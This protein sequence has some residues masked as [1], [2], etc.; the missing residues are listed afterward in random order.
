MADFTPK[1]WVEGERLPA[2]QM[3]RIEQGVADAHDKFDGGAML[4]VAKQGAADQIEQSP[5]P[6]SAFIEGDNL[7]FENADGTQTNAGQ[8]RAGD[9]VLGAAG[10]AATALLAAE[11]AAQSRLLSAQDALAA[12]QSRLASAQDA[13]SAL[14]SAQGAEEARVI[15]VGSLAGSQAA[16]MG[17]EAARD[18]ALAGQFL[19]TAIANTGVDFNTLTTPGVY[20]FST[21]AVSASA[22]APV[23]RPG[24]LQVFNIT[25]A[26]A[27]MQTYTPYGT[28]APAARGSYSRIASSASWQPWRYTT[29]HTAVSPVEQPGSTVTLWDEAAGV[30]R[31][32]SL[33]G[34]PLGTVDLDLVTLPG[35]YQ[36][37]SNGS[38]TL[39]KNYPKA[40][41]VGCLE[42]VSVTT[43]SLLIQRFTAFGGDS[44]SHPR[45]WIRRRSGA[46]WSPWSFMPTQRV[47]Q[48]A[49]RALYTYDEQNSRDQLIQGDTGWRDISSLLKDGWAGSVYIRREDYRVTV[50]FDAL[51]PAALTT[52]APLVLPLGFAPNVFDERFIL[53]HAIADTTP[54]AT[55]RRGRAFTNRII[56]IYCPAA[57]G[58]LYGSFSFSLTSAWPTALPGTAVGA[59]PNV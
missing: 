7:Y 3:N 53:H 26:T 59:I 55:V 33:V 15:A 4:D 32:L 24:V 21:A 25:G 6:V 45:T 10:N 50:R 39:A 19:G 35:A 16:R 44:I 46:G 36:Q 34:I 47:D 9:A 13:T 20:R 11:A 28:S 2:E 52:N 14:L 40:A 54:P 48:T 17:A 27:A 5:I 22:N 43:G 12:A 37:A 29:V 8:V 57:G 30:D 31:A 41:I 51:N 49:G 18:L 1:V 42:V 58:L 23:N 38:S 56:E